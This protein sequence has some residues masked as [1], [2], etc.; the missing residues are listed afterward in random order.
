MWIGSSGLDKS[1]CAMRAITALLV[2]LLWASGAQA[3]TSDPIGDCFGEDNERR[4][5][6]CTEIIDTLSPGPDL[7]SLAHAMRALALSLKGE[8]GLAI[9]DYDAAILLNPG[10][11]VAYNNRAWSRFKSGSAADGLPDVET[12]LRLSPGSSHA[13]DTRAH[14]RQSLGNLA[15]A[16]EDYERA[17]RFGGEK[18]V[19]LYQC[20]LQERGL[21]TGAVDGIYSD[22]VREALEACVRDASCDPLPADEQCRAATS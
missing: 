5:S 4:I 3:A 20:G 14:I 18:M 15:G 13:Y 11:S 9:H 21:Y 2:L 7:L 8:Y 1:I 19:K 22:P 6:G 17:M 10:F 12:A 16:L